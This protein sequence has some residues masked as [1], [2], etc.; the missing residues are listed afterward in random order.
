M[1]YRK[2]FWAGGEGKEKNFAKKRKKERGQFNVQKWERRRREKD[3]F[4]ERKLLAPV[5]GNL[6]RDKEKGEGEGLRCGKGTGALWHTGASLVG[7]QARFRVNFRGKGKERTSSLGKERRG[8][9]LI[10]LTRKKSPFYKGWVEK[11]L[12][13]K[14][15]GSR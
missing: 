2:R 4:L 10:S 14:G 12:Q 13:Q 6:Q 9:L 3:F 1:A 8:G 7:R 5:G 11:T 15:G